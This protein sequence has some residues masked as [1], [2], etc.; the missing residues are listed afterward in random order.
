MLGLSYTLA[1][2]VINN[3]GFFLDFKV[4]NY[5]LYGP[6]INSGFSRKPFRKYLNWEGTLLTPQLQFVVPFGAD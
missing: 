4:Y 1:L 2:R 6:E 3:P 5:A